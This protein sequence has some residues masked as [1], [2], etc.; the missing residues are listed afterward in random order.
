MQPDCN[1]TL[2]GAGLVYKIPCECG[3]K[4]LGE[5]GRPLQMRV[6]EHR[7]NWDKMKREKEE[8]MDLDSIPSLLAAHAVE[9]DHQVQWEEVKILAKESNVKKR[10]IHEAAAM[11]LEDEIISQPS[12]ELPPIWYPMFKEEKKII[13]TEKSKRKEKKS[14][15]H[16]SRKKERE[17]NRRG[18]ERRKED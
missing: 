8:G 10:K 9:N 5:T 14:Y 6:N 2:A 13:I 1:I 17:R 16:Y 12:F 11:Y 18:G 15:R 4:Y 7:R 3:A